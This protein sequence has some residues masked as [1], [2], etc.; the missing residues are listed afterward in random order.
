MPS[1]S[2]PGRT[3]KRFTAG[4][5][6]LYGS[7]LYRLTAL[8]GRGPSGLSAAPPDPWPGDAAHGQELL[9][10]VFRFAGQTL[11][12]ELPPWLDD[13]AGPAWLARMHGFDWLR[14]LR[15]VGGDAARRQA[16]LLV[17]HW[18]E[19]QGRW[20]P[21]AWAPDIMGGRLC[22]WI[23]QHDFFLASADDHLRARVFD[24]M[25]QQMRHLQR[26]VPGKL[27]GDALLLAIKGLAYGGLCLP[28]F[29]AAA[30]AARDLLVRELPRQ[31][32]PDGGHVERSP[33]VQL[34]TL[35]HLID[36]RTCF[37]TARAEVPEALQHAIDRMTPTLRFFRHG[38]GGLALFN[39]TAEQEA[40]LID[41]V[42][43]Q[44]DARGRPLKSL[45]HIGFERMNAG[46]ACLLMDTGAP[47]PPGLDAVAHAGTL[48]FELSV[49]RERL[50][51]NCGAH[52]SEFGPWRAALAATAAH[53]TVTVADTNSSS[54]MDEGGLVRRPRKV[55]VTRQDSD[56]GCL[57][58]ASHDGYR[59]A[60]GLIH[61]RRLFL[62]ENGEDLRGEDSLEGVG[63]AGQGKE[64][65]V[66]F[67]LHPTVQASI[68]NAGDA[69]LLRMASG[70]GW[71]LRVAGGVLELA[72]SVYLG[73][74]PEPRKSSQLVIRGLTG[75]G[76]T[77]VK[78]AL[79]REK[80]AAPRATART[81]DDDADGST[82]DLAT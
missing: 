13:A 23:G 21:V 62:F 3:H 44:A 1:P 55:E 10:N 45:P 34:H 24:S 12:A 58:E 70:Q 76:T 40:V 81:T 47:P 48:S 59:E 79:R 31:I 32:L 33:A 72:D 20:N 35:R 17:D 4:G 28:G 53:S 16:R 9:N 39:G 77:T 60:H 38:D 66:R 11:S 14:D 73:S 82:P 61:R 37:R 63:T 65:A 43:G 64:F 78:W 5:G 52:P 68:L 80:P 69:A 56:A 29:E 36:L 2:R 71:R 26:T 75:S 42:L 18:V 54:V 30:Q 8:A 41:T 27:R 74:G 25:A 19:T 51:V 22:A 46:R 7:A 6:W 15:A 50:I 57:V 49:G 67:H